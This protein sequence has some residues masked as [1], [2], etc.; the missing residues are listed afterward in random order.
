MINVGDAVAFTPDMSHAEISVRIEEST[1]F[2]P[3]MRHYFGHQG[4]VAQTARDGTRLRV[5]FGNDEEYWYPES[6]M[7]R[8]TDNAEAER[9]VAMYGADWDDASLPTEA[10]VLGV[11]N[12]FPPPPPLPPIGLSTRELPDPLSKFQLVYIAG[13]MSGFDDHNFPAFYEAERELREGFGLGTI[14]P[15]RLDAVQGEPDC[16]RWQGYL[17]RDLAEIAT[18]ADAVVVIDGWKNSRGASLEAYTAQQMG[19]PVFHLSGGELLPVGVVS[20]AY[21]AQSIVLGARRY[22]YGHPI[23]NFTLIANLW[24]ATMGHK[25]NEPLDIRDVAMMMIQIKVAREYNAP[26]QDNRIDIAGYALAYDE[27]LHE[28]EARG[29]PPDGLVRRDIAKLRQTAPN[30]LNESR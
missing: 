9:M 26:K 30:G 29:L 23:D 11:K 7:T 8:V 20:V 19:M 21:E 12:P 3:A 10:P 25:M 17:R 22:D 18:R 2:I 15:A 24:N 4:V 13:P 16:G 6:V 5:D 28:A 14:N 1:G 27:S